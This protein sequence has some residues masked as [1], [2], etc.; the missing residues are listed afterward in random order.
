MWAPS[1][2]LIAKPC[3]VCDK[4]T[5]SD[6]V[7]PVCPTCFEAYLAANPEVEFDDPQTTLKA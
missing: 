6:R 3:Y 7:P 2:E 1:R 5:I 4:Q